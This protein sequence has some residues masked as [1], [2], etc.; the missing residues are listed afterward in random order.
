M[1]PLRRSL[2]IILV[3]ALV[4]AGMVGRTGMASASAAPSPPEPAQ[5][6]ATQPPAPP[7]PSTG[8]PDTGSTSSHQSV[9]PVLRP[10]N[11]AGA[12]WIAVFALRGLGWTS[13]VWVRHVLGVGE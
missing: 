10:G 1:Q 2:L 3:L 9:G 11:A 6:A 7:G 12:S 5:P 8:E 4:S 13:L